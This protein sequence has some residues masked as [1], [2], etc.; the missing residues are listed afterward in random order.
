V[1]AKALSG[2]GFLALLGD[3]DGVF[4]RA[5]AKHVSVDRHLISRMVDQGRWQVIGPAVVVNH[6]GA[7]TDRQKAWAGVLHAGPGGAL[8]GL[9]ALSMLNLRG[10]PSS[11]VQVVAEH[12]KGRRNLD[13][14]WMS[15]R[16]HESV[17]MGDEDI[18]PTL[19]PRRQRVAR[20]AVDAAA[21][22][23]HDNRARSIIAAVVQ[24]RLALPAE[25]RAFV[26]KRPT[27]PRHGLLLE[28]IDDVE[29]G[30][31]SLPEL[32]WT[33]GLR[34]LGLPRPT[35][36]RVL[37][38]PNGTYYLDA[39][40]EEWL[41]T[42]EINGGQHLDPR[43]VDY[44]D[45][46]RLVVSATGR[47]VVG[48]SSYLVRREFSRAGLRTARALQS[49]GWRPAPSTLAKLQRIAAQRGEQLWLPQLAAP[50]LERPA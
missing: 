2:A 4:T 8:F 19:A 29:G 46:R 31:Q 40:F 18:H 26:A 9:S 38:H 37:R 23:P 33:T 16:V 13:A 25:L 42:V 21:V 3:Q 32:E 28:T 43:S 36:Q 10:F 11:A 1:A 24:Q 44:D 47:L 14:R 6:T 20:A 5:Q 39:D 41:V 12:G 35:Q 49:R 45:D 27:L 17:H 15:I 7:L 22:A 50:E 30:A 48:I 34:R